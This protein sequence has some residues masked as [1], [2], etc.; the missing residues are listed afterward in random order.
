MSALV[1]HDVLAFLVGSSCF[2]VSHGG[3]GNG[4]RPVGSD[5]TE[6]VDTAVVQ[7][8]RWYFLE[9]CFSAGWLRAVVSED[10]C[11]NGET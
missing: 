5:L 2:S 4:G 7:L 10:S 11:C 8:A 1:L 9:F 3:R 6:C